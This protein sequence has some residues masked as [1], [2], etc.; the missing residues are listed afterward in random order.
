MTYNKPHIQIVKSLHFCSHSCAEVRFCSRDGNLEALI[1]LVAGVW[2]FLF[3]FPTFLTF[4]GCYMA[5]E[6]PVSP[7]GP[8][9]DQ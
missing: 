9:T 4:L 5:T 2:P 3:S 7:A 8:P 1:S 6:A